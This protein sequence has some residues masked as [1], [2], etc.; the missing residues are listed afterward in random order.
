VFDL[1]TCALLFALL[2]RAAG[3]R[4]AIAGALGYALHPAVVYESAVWGQ[5]DAL[6]TFF[7]AAALL[8]H[9]RGRDA[10]SPPLFALALLCKAQAIVFAPLGLLLLARRPR[11]LLLGTLLAALTTA[12]VLAPLLS[13]PGALAAAARSYTTSVGR[14]PALSLN[15]YNLWW[16]LFAEAAV[17]KPD[18]DLL[19]GLVS[20]RTAGLALLAAAV[21][22]LLATLAPTL[23]ARTRTTTFA[24]LSP[25]LAAGLI[26]G[27]FQLLA[28]EMHER[29]LF[30]SMALSLP[31]VALGRRGAVLYALHSLAFFLNLLAVLPWGRLDRALFAEF[32]MLDVVL[33]LGQT[34]LFFATWRYVLQEQAKDQAAEALAP[35]PNRPPA[36]LHPLPAPTALP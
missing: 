13:H 31:L 1:A 20:Y 29:Y 5:S 8:A 19:L 3:E 16:A 6:Y 10:L 27:A 32:P 18:T 36:A 4:A 25:F 22:G 7:V 35:E 11:P 30:P 34:A 9:V 15:A 26:A 17:G 14:Y 33:A 28:T 24:R 23:L 12:A 2:R 21:V